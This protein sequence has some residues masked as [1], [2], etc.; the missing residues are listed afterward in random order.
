[1]KAHKTIHAVAATVFSI[2]T[3]VHVLR[4]SYGWPVVVGSWVA[5]MWLSWLAVFLAGSLA[6]LLWKHAR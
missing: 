6:V 2:V 5:P 4:L 3:L 1:M